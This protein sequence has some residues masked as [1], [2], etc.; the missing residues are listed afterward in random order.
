VSANV[1]GVLSSRT[2]RL[3]E[4]VPEGATPDHLA[5]G[6]GGVW[7][8]NA[9]ANTV[10]RIDPAK[11]VRVQTINVGSSPSGIATGEDAVWVAN[12]LDGT[13]SWINPVTNAVVQTT[14]VGNGPEG[15]AFGANSVWVANTA[16]GTIARLD[17]LNGKVTERIDSPANELAYGGNAL[18]ATDS[19]GDSVSRINPVTN[20]VAETI[21]VGRGP[22]GVAF[23][24]N[25]AWVANE[26]DGTVSRIDA[27]TN[28]IDATIPVGG[29]PNGI[30]AGAGAI[31]VS[32]ASGRTLTRIDPENN[33]VDH[34]VEIGSPT[35]GVAVD[36]VNSRVLIGIGPSGAGHRGGTLRLRTNFIGSIDT[37]VAYGVNEWSVLNLTGDGLTGFK[38]I[39]GTEGAQL[40][41]DLAVSIPTPTNFG[42][43][44]SFR[45][46]RNIRYSSGVRLEASDIRYALER[47]FRLGAAA[48]AGVY[49][50]IVGASAC[51][52]VPRRCDLSKGVVA[53]D[54][55]GTV[56]FHLSAPDPEF[57]YKLALPFAYA[58]PAG[59][60]MRDVGTHPQP[61]TGPYVVASYR[62]RHLLTLHRN[63]HF[64][65]WSRAAQPKGY[66]DQIVLRIGGTADGALE[67]IEGGNADV[68]DSW[69]PGALSSGRLRQLRTR[70]AG[71]LHVN[72][73]PVTVGFFLNTHL[74]PFDDVR[75]RRAL[76]YAA[77]RALAV[78]RLGGPDAGRPTCQILPPDFP[79][80][81]HYCPYATDLARAQRLTAASTKS[82]TRVTVWF[83]PWA[84]PWLKDLGPYVAKLLDSL[85][86]RASVAVERPSTDIRREQAGFVAWAADYPGAWDFLTPLSCGSWSQFCDPSL[87]RQQGAALNAESTSP[88][89]ANLLWAGIDRR[90]VNEAA[91]LPLVTPKWI[92]FLSKR[93]GNYQYN[94]EWG[95]LLDQLWVR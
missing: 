15:V 72:P 13:V 54:A 90:I 76:N 68:F 55:S 63:V 27:S 12:N 33:R 16:D 89:A 71:Q 43:T 92:D 6:E 31:W 35:S 3:A 59:T 73:R 60:P 94:P 44:Y 40:V 58:V 42:R 37:A 28:G 46:R 10:S 52:K 19:S 9:A 95:M 25:S 85:G 70:F 62:P 7:V 69:G 23:G 84:Q 2:G 5:I 4:Q 21:H 22:A 83:S 79:G 50:R 39:G 74:P 87:D 11:W 91:W 65:E 61:A 80:Y 47:D 20:T 38:R 29:D 57:L 81:E 45:V 66:P 77:D 49:G 30:A 34:Q 26:L 17:A 78:T 51:V 75:A 14:P 93:V 64:H 86:Y 32:N 53:D 18:W 67:A 41:P 8:T 24:F 88:Q 48:P 1:I 36:N 56:T 82:G